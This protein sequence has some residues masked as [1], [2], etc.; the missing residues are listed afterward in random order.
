MFSDWKVENYSFFKTNH[1]NWVGWIIEY[2]TQNRSTKHDYWFELT[3]LHCIYVLLW[4]SRYLSMTN[5]YFIMLIVLKCILINI[6]IPHHFPWHMKCQTENCLPAVWLLFIPDYIHIVPLTYLKTVIV[7]WWFE[8][9]LFF[10][11]W[12]VSSYYC[13][14][15]LIF[16]FSPMAPSSISWSM[17]VIPLPPPSFSKKLQFSPNLIKIVRG[18]TRR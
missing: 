16:I 15:P 7:S 9:I 8:I 14:T 17:G 13:C 11:V 1:S 12:N 18:F 5:R 6:N 2:K 3:V 10:N 4:L